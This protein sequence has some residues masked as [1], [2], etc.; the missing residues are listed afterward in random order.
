MNNH[1]KDYFHSIYGSTPTFTRLREGGGIG[2]T[3][4]GATEPKP[5]PSLQRGGLSPPWPRAPPLGFHPLDPQLGG[6]GFNPKPQKIFRG[7]EV[8]YQFGECSMFHFI[9]LVRLK[10]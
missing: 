6:G 10:G 5:P 1:N 4:G 8:K 7:A 3:R 2:A 9:H